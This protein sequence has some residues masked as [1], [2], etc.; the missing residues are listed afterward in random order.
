MKF[1]S[2]SGKKEVSILNRETEVDV[3]NLGILGSPHS[4][5]W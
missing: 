3:E 1:G 2:G 4:N 5:I